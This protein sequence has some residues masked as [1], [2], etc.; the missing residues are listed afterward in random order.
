MVDSSAIREKGKLPNMTTL[1][2]WF[3]FVVTRYHLLPLVVVRS[4]SLWHSHIFLYKEA[5]IYACFF[6]NDVDVF[7][8][9]FKENKHFSIDTSHNRLLLKPGPGP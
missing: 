8:R 4:H 5:P 2:H 1:F 3:S 7:L 6:L 9:I